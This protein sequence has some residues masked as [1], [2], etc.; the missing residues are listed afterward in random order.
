MGS[1]N[2]FFKNL[3]QQGVRVWMTMR[4]VRNMILGHVL[5]TKDSLNLQIKHLVVRCFLTNPHR[6]AWV[7]CCRKIP[8]GQKTAQIQ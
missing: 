7:I 2:D 5:L 6:P 4:K 3:E 1:L 8:L